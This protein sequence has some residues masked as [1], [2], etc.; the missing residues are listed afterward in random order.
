MS[1]GLNTPNLSEYFRKSNQF[2]YFLT[3]NNGVLLFTN[4]LFQQ[5]FGKTDDVSPSGYFK[6]DEEFKKIINDCLENKNYPVQAN[7]EMQQIDGLINSVKWEFSFCS[8][9]DGTAGCVQAIGIPD[10]NC[11][12]GLKELGH[13]AGIIPEKIRAYEDSAEGIWRFELKIPINKSAPEEEILAH[14][15]KHAF[16]AECNDKMASMYGYENASELLGVSMDDLIDFS[17][18]SIVEKFFEFYRNDFQTSLIETK[19][20]DRFGNTKYFQNTMHGTVEN[21]MLKRI[22]GTQHDITEQRLAEEKIKYLAMLTENVSDVIIS[23]DTNFNIVSWNKAAE[24][25]SGYKAEEIIGRKITDVFR[26]DFQNTSLT[27]LV[28]V[29]NKK[30]VWSGELFVKNKFGEDII[31]LITKTSLIGEDG[32]VKGYVAVCK[33]ITETR[34]AEEKLKQS[35]LFFRTLISES[36]DGVSLTDEKGVV[37]FAAASGLKVLGFELEDI[38]GKNVFDFIHPDDTGIALQA[39]NNELSKGKSYS[40]AIRLINSDGQWLWCNVRGRNMLDNPNVKKMVIYYHDDTARIKVEQQLQ[41]QAAILANVS[42]L[43]MTTDFELRI[44][45]WNKIAEQVVGYSAEETIGKFLGEIVK[46]DYGNITSQQSADELEKNGFWQGEISFLNKQGLRKTIL[47]TATYLLNEIGERTAIIGTGKDITEKKKAEEQLKESELFYKNLFANSLDGVLIT[48]E[49]SKIKF[50][51]PSVTVTL[52]YDPK[53]VLGKITFDFAH[54]DDV[55]L[56]QSAF[57]EELEG[58][59]SQTFISVR[60]RHKKGHWVW[61]NVRGHNQLDNPYIG[62]LLVYLYN[63]TMRKN[64]ELALIENERQFRTQAMVLENVTDIIVTTDLQHRVTSWNK[65]IE[66][67]TGISAEEAIGQPLYNILDT[68]Y[69]PYTRKQVEEI[70]FLHGIWK[71]EVKLYGF[72]GEVKHFLYTVSLF[73]NEKG[74]K[75]GVLEVGRDV[76]ERKKAE[77]LLQKSELFYRS[78]IYY[79]LDGIVMTDE[80]GVIKYCAPSASKVSGYKPEELL[81]HNLVEFIHP[82]DI[83]ISKEVFQHELHKESVVNYIHLRLLHA[84]GNWVWCIVRGHNLLRNPS[85]NS[86]VIYFTDDSKRKLIE[87]KLKESEF[88]FRNLI[89]NLKQGILL[90]DEKG[91]MILSNSAALEMLGMTEEQLLGTTSFDPRWNVIHDDGSDFPSS[92]HPMPKAVRTK[93]SIRDVVMGVYRPEKDDQIW[94]LV[95][96]DPIFDFDG[97]FVNI[98]CSFTD[99]TEQKRLSKELVEQEIKKQKELTQATIDGQEKERMEIGKE[100]HDSVNQQLTTTR[101]YLEVIKDKVNGEIKELIGRSHENLVAVIKEIRTLSQSLVPPSLGD[102]GLVASIQEL[103]DSIRQTH[104]LKVEFSHRHFNEKK[105]PDNFKLML[106]RITQEQVNNVIKHAGAKLMKIKL[107]SDA[108]FVTLS[109]ND[110]GVGFNVNNYQKGIGF[111]NMTNRVSLFN[112]RIEK[113]SSPGNG[114]LLTVNVPMPNDITDTKS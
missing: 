65:V 90:Q 55:A 27:G 44:L 74:E 38:I 28:E 89:F 110:D 53:E 54:P 4:L 23:Q 48:D 51:S 33:N 105:L 112:G 56:A 5:L 70:V 1:F 73:Y 26:L 25:L 72:K 109:I 20:Y 10:K 18:N 49:T 11:N 62:G 17:D 83:S 104:I 114:C 93:K 37:S 71:G 87:D 101:L 21:G 102:I 7:L 58:R 22:W 94:L 99:I 2:F 61:C 29:L 92:E 14:A 84:N 30:E 86:I 12:T 60:L 79:S 42:D 82:D 36:L 113:E 68:D 97:N 81:G 88:R 108:E 46:P 76:T 40:I 91:K 32:K 69:T 31:L 52:G 85:F 34:R 95:N 50:A 107:Q 15:R 66:I 80:N 47:H 39:F 111:K 59:P 100:L 57:K 19:E 77:A 13:K 64:M 106:F 67:T 41:Q 9:I 35:E 75:I 24:Q 16:L 8:G 6:N 78:M 103:C 3:D 96:A 45:T 43:I 98:I 63:D